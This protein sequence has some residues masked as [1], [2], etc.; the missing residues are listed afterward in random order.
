MYVL[1]GPKWELNLGG[2]RISSSFPNLQAALYKIDLYDFV[3]D[4][5]CGTLEKKIRLNKIT[6]CPCFTSRA[7]LTEYPRNCHMP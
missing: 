6:W 5:L 1:Y 7:V 3:M 2:R 4:E